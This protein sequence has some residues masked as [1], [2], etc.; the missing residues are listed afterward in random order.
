MSTE[1]PHPAS[2]C[3]AY[4]WEIS[5]R[6]ERVEQKRP[7]VRKCVGP[8]LDAAT[9]AQGDHEGRPRD[10]PET[11]RSVGGSYGSF[12]GGWGSPAEAGEARGSGR[13]S[14]Q[15]AT[16]VAAGARELAKVSEPS[17]PSRKLTE[18]RLAADEGNWLSEIKPS[19]AV[20]RGRGPTRR[21]AHGRDLISRI[22]PRWA[23]E[24]ILRRSQLQGGSHEKARAR[25]VRVEPSRRI[26]T[27][28]RGS[29][30]G[31]QG[32]VRQ[33]PG[34]T[35]GLPRLEGPLHKVQEISEG[36]CPGGQSRPHPHGSMRGGRTA[37]A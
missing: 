15:L 1:R 5:P 32:Q 14:L 28:L 10:T 35:Q 31:C 6:R 22:L 36:F 37:A 9:L 23:A 18:G 12:E 21:T 33:M 7:N 27:V 16:L 24:R 17:L 3:G 11:V 34:Q 19:P 8:L 30:Q 26:R 2:S 4:S 13:A 29:V 20:S 25:I